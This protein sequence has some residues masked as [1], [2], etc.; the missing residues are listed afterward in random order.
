MVHQKFFLEEVEKPIPK[1]NEVL[2]K[3]HATTVTAGDVRMRSFSLPSMEW[4]FLRLYLGLRKP[5]RPLLGMEIAGEIEEIGKDVKLFQKGDQFYASTFTVNFG[6]YAQYKCF[7]EDGMLA[8]KPANM[9][10]EEAATVPVLMLT[11]MWKKGI[12]R[13]MW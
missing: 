6:G 12:K 7:P 2:V 13:E 10:F 11:D 3:V 5:R 1:N 8:L 4:L 9:T